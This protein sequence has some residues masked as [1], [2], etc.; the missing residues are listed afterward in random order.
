MPRAI[1]KWTFHTFKT[2]SNLLNGPSL[3]ILAWAIPL[4]HFFFHLENP[5]ALLTYLRLLSFSLAKRIDY[6]EVSQWHLCTNSTEELS[7]YFF[8]FPIRCASHTD[9][10]LS[11][12]RFSTGLKNRWQISINTRQCLSDPSLKTDIAGVMTHR[13][14]SNIPELIWS[15]F[16]QPNLI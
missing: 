10:F 13:N 6:C 1:N 8:L 12:F 16:L 3:L 5:L 9:F 2:Q 11:E 14:P 4:W 7:F 15:S